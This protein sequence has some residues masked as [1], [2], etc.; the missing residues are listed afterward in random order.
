MLP[1][2]HKRR[3]TKGRPRCSII[4][5]DGRLYHF[6]TSSSTLTQNNQESLQ[7]FQRETTTFEPV[8][9]DLHGVSKEFSSNPSNCFP[10]SIALYSIST[11]YERKIPSMHWPI[12]LRYPHGLSRFFRFL[13][14]QAV[15][16]NAPD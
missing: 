3:I 12:F 2:E 9:S 1:Q 16:E 10:T 15:R 14:K 5:P 6:I 7:C 13:R 11:T 4:Y 8:S